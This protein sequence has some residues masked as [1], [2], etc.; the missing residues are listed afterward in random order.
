MSSSRF[1]LFFSWFWFAASV[2]LFSSASETLRAEIPLQRIILR[3]KVVAEYDKT[4][5]NTVWVGIFAGRED[6]VAY[7][8]TRADG[9]FR[10]DRSLLPGT[11]WVELRPVNHLF[12]NTDL[13]IELPTPAPSDPEDARRAAQRF[14][15]GRRIL[16]DPANDVVVDHVVGKTGENRETVEEIASAL[17][18]VVDQLSV[19]ETVTFNLPMVEDTRLTTV[20]L[21]GS[22]RGLLG[23]GRLRGGI[24][25]FLWRGHEITSVPTD[26][27][28]RFERD[29]VQV[30]I[31]TIKV[32]AGDRFGLF[33]RVE[34]EIEITPETNLVQLDDLVCG[35]RGWVKAT[36]VVLLALVVWF[37][38]RG[39]RKTRRDV[40][41]PEPSA[42]P[43]AS[44]SSTKDMPL[45]FDA[46]SERME[47]GL[48][49]LRGAGRKIWHTPTEPRE[50]LRVT[51][52]FYIHGGIC[53][54]LAIWAGLQLYGNTIL[55]SGP[56]CREE[57]EA[58]SHAQQLKR[59]IQE[60]D[61]ELYI[62]S[63]QVGENFTP[64][65]VFAWSR[66][67]SVSAFQR[68][69]W[70]TV[71]LILFCT[72]AFLVFAAAW[73]L[74]QRIL[75][76]PSGG[77]IAGLG[78]AALL[79]LCPA[80]IRYSCTLYPETFSLFLMSASLLVWTL[81]GVT[82]VRPTFLFLSFLLGF[83]FL[84][85]P[86]HGLLLVTILGIATLLRTKPFERN[87]ADLAC[88][89][90]PA[91]VLVFVVSRVYLPE[92]SRRV[93]AF[94]GRGDDLG[95]LRGIAWFFERM[96]IDYAPHRWIMIVVLLVLVAVSWSL[97]D[98]RLRGLAAGLAG[99]VVTLIVFVGGKY[100]SSLLA[101]M[102]VL[103]LFFGVAVEVIVAH[104]GRGK[105][106]SYA[107]TAATLLLLILPLRQ[108]H[109]VQR[110]YY[111]T[112][113]DWNAVLEKLLPTIDTE[114]GAL[115]IGE[116]SQMP[117][118]AVNVHLV[119]DYDA[120]L[121]KIYRPSL[122]GS[123]APDGER[124][125]DA[126]ESAMELAR[127]LQNDL[128]GSVNTIELLPGH[129]LLES[130]QYL[131]FENWTRTWVSLMKYQPWYPETE[132]IPFEDRN[133]NIHVYRRDIEATHIGRSRRIDTAS[134]GIVRMALLDQAGRY[135][136]NVRN[137]A[138]M[139]VRSEVVNLSEE[140]LKAYLWWLISDRFTERPWEKKHAEARQDV[141]LPRN[142]RQEF[143]AKLT[144]PNESG[145]YWLVAYLRSEDVHLDAAFLAEDV[146]VGRP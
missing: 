52:W 47:K 133:L 55:S 88:L 99:G 81:A 118:A 20:S 127:W 39:G 18:D 15:W 14:M 112:T 84:Y 23:R 122:Q 59:A 50:S 32:I 68:I 108:G 115:L 31:G 22:I 62:E 144:M 48:E 116:N 5:V 106:K 65:Q 126:T 136:T 43:T 36:L 107:L 138:A 76:S 120:D 83:T 19:E 33:Q 21:R 97:M 25:R 53:L 9:T 105:D 113:A 82:P 75:Q 130:P 11:Y 129:P 24:A 102:P 49:W 145:R 79:I 6:P 57:A 103:A 93:H 80:A 123:I 72:S 78:A 71:H 124:I 100:W 139:Q 4:P 91:T 64:F 142:G 42:E 135:V 8:W 30:P 85:H 128:V 140:P 109:L 70:Q 13:Q 40:R 2:L 90:L 61:N 110:H 41:P 104:A 87:L 77:S 96:T 29:F 67:L 69:A 119:K 143:T 35:L 26:S 37:V 114:R 63:L 101:F 16:D 73:M 54:L 44:E 74:S 92:T 38:F 94:L 66:I 58:V 132:A 117:P 12:E 7:A 28:H 98:R 51:Q 60:G 46:L 95:G 27:G 121:E 146:V 89:I 131:K 125:S 86:V 45:D 10:C 134:A 17:L 3:G 137:G 34:R 1:P 111:A 56:L 141:E